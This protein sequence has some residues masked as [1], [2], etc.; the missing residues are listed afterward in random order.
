[1]CAHG[2]DAWFADCRNACCHLLPASRM[3]LISR[4]ALR[5]RYGLILRLMMLDATTDRFGR[6]IGIEGS[7]NCIYFIVS[8]NTSLLTCMRIFTM[9]TYTGWVCVWKGL[10][11]FVVVS[12]PNKNPGES[13]LVSHCVCMRVIEM[14]SSRQ[15]TQIQIWSTA[16]EKKK[17]GFLFPIHT[18]SRNR[19]FTGF[20]AR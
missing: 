7:I 1:M 9:D 3:K 11:G 18:P 14:W 6:G 12:A 8:W 5:N 13:D 20:H 19:T 2:A 17:G 15:R 16:H 10:N 4:I